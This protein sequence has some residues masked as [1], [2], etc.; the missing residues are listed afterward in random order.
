MYFSKILSNFIA[1]SLKQRFKN[2]VDSLPDADL[3]FPEMK[4]ESLMS[5]RS[6][7]HDSGTS[8]PLTN[9]APSKL[10]H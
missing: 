2:A 9:S 10:G 1:K 5:I 6:G 4:T 8:R 7:S 3:N